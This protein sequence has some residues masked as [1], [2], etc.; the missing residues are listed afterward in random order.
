[1]DNKGY[2][3]APLTVKPVN[4]HDSELLPESFEKLL[5]WADLIGIQEDLEDSHFT[6][7]AGFDS[8]ANKDLIRDFKLNPVIYPNRRGTKDYTKIE[9]M[10]ADFPKKVYLERYK[11]ERTFAWKHKYR[12][13]T[14]RYERLHT[15]STGIRYL[16][17][18]MINLREF[19]GNF[20]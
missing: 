12:K 5:D 6:L 16:A 13:L 18:S 14:L 15:T 4:Q 10:F 3:I 17:Y 7:D 19:L 20:V 8:R 1:V 9:K 2:I 11:V